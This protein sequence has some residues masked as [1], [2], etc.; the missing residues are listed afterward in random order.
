M[1]VSTSLGLGGADRQVLDLALAFDERGWTVAVVS[2]IPPEPWPSE[3]V[4]AGI[5]VATLGMRP[6]IADPRS[7]ARFAR[8]VR[9]W[10]A[11]VVHSHMFH[12]N[13]LAR[14]T[15]PLGSMPVLISTMHSANEGRQWRYAAYRV[16]RS[17]SDITTAVS[18]AAIDEATRRRAAPPG[19][20][21]LVHNGTAIRR[22]VEDP[23]VRSAVRDE[24]GVASAFLW[25]A[26]GRLV[27]AKGYPELVEAFH[28][29]H[30]RRPTARLVIAG[31]GP[32]QDEIHGLVQAS[33]L[34]SIV[35]LL[36]PRSDVPALMQAADG[37]VLS[38]RWE[39]LP[40]V[41]LEGAASALPIV[42]TA[43]GGNGEIV[44][45][46]VTGLLAPAQNPAALAAA[47]EKI[48]RMP[49]ARRRAMGSAGRERVVEL[50]DLQ[51]V[52]DAWEAIYLERLR[53]RGH[54]RPPASPTVAGDPVQNVP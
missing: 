11:D 13:L 19:R 49:A 34:D 12:A 47:M 40:M 18:Q 33:G 21:R 53:A 17:L 37:L 20:I 3:L 4:E 27:E 32:L 8:L 50:F 31:A 10:K 35:T 15:R 45:D 22:F 41:L 30:H 39:G 2:L 5:H 23:S 29:V 38:S 36:G 48:M 9:R 52:V 26:A 46:G 28:E 51:R 1:L 6:G 24:L 16:T 25:L 14:L 44:E 54:R 7:L 43:V 42:A